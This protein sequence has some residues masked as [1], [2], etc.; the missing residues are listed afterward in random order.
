LAPQKFNGLA[1]W[2]FGRQYGRQV[3]WQAGCL[4]GRQFCSSAVLQFDSL[5]VWQFGSL[6]VWLFGSSA[7]R[8]FGSFVIDQQSRT[9]GTQDPAPL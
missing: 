5:A 6:V 2:Q 7:V 1:G 8:Q 4:A 3:V 9:W